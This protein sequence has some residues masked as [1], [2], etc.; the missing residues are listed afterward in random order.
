MLNQYQIIEVNGKFINMP[1]WKWERN[2]IIINFVWI[3]RFTPRYMYS[4]QQ[5]PNYLSGSGYVFTIDT[6]TKLYN[7][8]M[9][10]PL[11]YLEDVY[12]TG[13]FEVKLKNW[14]LVNT[15]LR[16]KNIYFSRHLCWKS[17]NKTNQSPFVQLFVVQGCLRSSG[18]NYRAWNQSKWNENDI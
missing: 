8:S 4:R 1:F 10:M 17:C 13:N 9:E 6:A 12:T 5:F 15:F 11:L 2:E 18:D 14:V 16:E 3:V 7:A